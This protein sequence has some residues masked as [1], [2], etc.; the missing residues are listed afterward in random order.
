MSSLR[1]ESIA[2]PEMTSWEGTKG[3]SSLYI[4]SEIYPK[5]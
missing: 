3:V 2:K 4:A 1:K 5:G